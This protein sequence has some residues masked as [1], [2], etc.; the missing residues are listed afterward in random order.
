MPGEITR[1][2][3]DIDLRS[4]AVDARVTVAKHLIRRAVNSGIINE[5]DIAYFLEDED[6]RITL[7]KGKENSFII[8]VEE[9]TT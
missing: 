9:V 7:N 2:V 8:K 1:L 6:F 5:A 4:Y 3:L